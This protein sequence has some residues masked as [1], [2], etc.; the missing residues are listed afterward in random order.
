MHVV[1]EKSGGEATT[2]SELS[3]Q[4]NSISLVRETE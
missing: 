4:I 1:D 2:D 3:T